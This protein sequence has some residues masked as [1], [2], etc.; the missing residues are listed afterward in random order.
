MFEIGSSMEEIETPAL[1]IDLNVLDRNIRRMA[2][3]F[4]SVESSLKPHTK[5]HKTPIIAHKQIK[6]GAIGICCQKLGE[7]EVMVNAGIDNILITNRQCD[8]PPET[9]DFE[10]DSPNIWHFVTGDRLI[11]IGF[12]RKKTLHI[13]EYSI[14]EIIECKEETLVYGN[15]ITYLFDENTGFPL[16]GRLSSDTP[17]PELKSAMQQA[18]DVNASLGLPRSIAI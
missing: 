13:N 7:A 5:T 6:A 17:S 15:S 11:L 12:A 14:V 16:F 9:R 4:S 8:M 18:L 1:L 10:L 2:D 3:Y